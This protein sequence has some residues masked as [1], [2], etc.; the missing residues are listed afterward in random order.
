VK[1]LRRQPPY[2]FVLAVACD[3]SK[4]ARDIFREEM[5]SRGIK[6]FAI[7]ARGELEDMLFQSKNDRLLFAYFGISL[8]PRL[9]SLGTALRTQ[10]ARKK[11]LA[12]LLGEEN[13]RDTFVLLRDPT[14]DRYP[15]NPKEGE[16]PARWIVRQALHL[17]EPGHLTVINHEHLAATTPDGLGWDVL[18]ETDLS[19]HMVHSELRSKNAWSIKDTYQ[20]KKDAHDFWNEY[21]DE[22]DQAYLKRYREVPIE[23]VLAIDL[24]GDGYYPIPHILI[25]FDDI[26]GPFSKSNWSSLERARIGGGQINLRT[27]NKNHVKIFPN[28]LPILSDPAPK[29][30]DQTGQSK[31]LSKATLEKLTTIFSKFSERRPTKSSIPVSSEESIKL[32]NEKMR[33]FCEWRAD[34]AQQVFSSFVHKLRKAGH[35]ARVRVRSVKPSS[36]RSGTESVELRIGMC[37]QVTGNPNYRTKG[38]LRFWMDEYRG[39]QM[40]VSPKADE[41]KTGYSPSPTPPLSIENMPKDKLEEHV[42]EVLER[43]QS[44]EII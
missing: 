24:L 12:A 21:I 6:E 16:P 38:H 40:E 34:V 2:G 19:E 14:D 27:E 35:T 30:F 10:I 18:L 22:I 5:V 29:D 42:L 37:V 25:P 9:R 20:K 8:Q 39:W 26:T 28:P 31:S 32:F 15:H 41:R 17:K 13:R 1:A 4:N 33:P 23:R 3:I 43:L 36:W 11:Q 7:W 44:P